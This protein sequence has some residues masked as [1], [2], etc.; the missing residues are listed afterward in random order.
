MNRYALVVWSD[1]YKVG[2]ALIDNDHKSLFASFNRFLKQV[3]VSETKSSISY[4]C[5]ILESYVSYHF[6]HEEEFMSAINYDGIDDHVALHHKLIDELMVAKADMLKNTITAAQFCEFFR[7]WLINHV[8]VEDKKIADFVTASV[9]GG[10][11]PPGIS[12]GLSAKRCHASPDAGDSGEG[13]DG[14]QGDM[15]EMGIGI[16]GEGLG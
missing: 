4:G 14:G 15:G 9:K 10:V 11:N 16:V 12:P 5:D 13:A 8:V 3:A 6:R 7:T 1:E 2:I